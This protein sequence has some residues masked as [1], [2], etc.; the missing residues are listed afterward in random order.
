[1]HY[2]IV[3]LEQKIL[4]GVSTTTSN[5]DP[6]MGEKIGGLWNSLYQDGV[7]QR[8][9]NKANDYAIGLYSEYSP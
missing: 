5:N 2:E 1:M 8:I 6:A 9:Q 4:V 3:N 7:S